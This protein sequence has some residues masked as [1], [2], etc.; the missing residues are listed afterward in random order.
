MKTE[1]PFE[2]SKP[3]IA[4]Y[5]HR[6]GTTAD[7]LPAGVDPATH[8]EDYEDHREDEYIEVHDLREPYASAPALL[9]ENARMRE[10]L[11]ELLD[12]E[13]RIYNAP[14]ET[15]RAEFYLTPMVEARA[16]ARAALAEG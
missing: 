9:S 12:T 14:D 11:A 5:S 3:K 4:V 7:I 16:K 13:A 1:K 8:F 10:A 6:F 15:G 2:V